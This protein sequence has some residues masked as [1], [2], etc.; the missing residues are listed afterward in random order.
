VDLSGKLDSGLEALAGASREAQE[1]LSDVRKAVSEASADVAKK[2]EAA[3]L[4]QKGVAALVTSSLTSVAAKLDALDARVEEQQQQQQEQAADLGPV[5][6]SL[7]AIKGQLQEQ[8]K[9]AGRNQEALKA[10]LGGLGTVLGSVDAKLDGVVL[11]ISQLGEY[12]DMGLAGLLSE[13]QGGNAGVKGACDQ[14]ARTVGELQART[15]EQAGAGERLAVLEAGQRSV[16]DALQQLQAASPEAS[17]QRLEQ[18][19]AKLEQR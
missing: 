3:S 11:G 19:I 6:E 5:K 10:V 7:E 18:A 12:L 8:A 4:T 13:I 14:L 9:A 17:R 2:L 1:E 15:S 16:L